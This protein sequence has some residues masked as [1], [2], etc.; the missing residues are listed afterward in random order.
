MSTRA[1]LPVGHARTMVSGARSPR[2]YGEVARQLAAGL[3]DERPDLEPYP[4]AV[5]AWATAEAQAA[6]LRRHLDEV[7]I[8]DEATGEPRKAPLHWLN[9]AERR[10]QKAREP[11]GLDPMSEAQLMRERAAAASGVVD[12]NALAERGRA[13]RAEYEAVGLPDPTD[14]PDI[15]GQVLHAVR[16]DAAAREVA[17]ELE[18]LL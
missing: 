3:L 15:A 2:V 8:I 12:L 9:V 18:H 10:A 1:P 16:A 5:A 17:N 14:H 4:E 11:L 6:L 7:G 13:A